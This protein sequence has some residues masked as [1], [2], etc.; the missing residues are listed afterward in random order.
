[1]NMYVVYVDAGNGHGMMEKG[2][3]QRMQKQTAGV[4][5][6]NRQRAVEDGRE[7]PP[8]YTPVPPVGSFEAECWDKAVEIFR[9]ELGR[10]WK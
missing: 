6:A 5:E 8:P 7:P 4:V 9:G 1:M 10:R 3:Y 2:Q